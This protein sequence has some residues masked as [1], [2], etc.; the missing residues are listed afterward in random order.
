M[1]V[2]K[3]LFSSEKGLFCLALVVAASVLAIMGKLTVDQWISYTEWIAAVYVGGKAIQGAGAA[4]G[5]GKSA[6][7]EERLNANDDVIDELVEKLEAKP[8]GKIES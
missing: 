7:L 6:A 8:V 3:D 5:N 2:L 1:K 4:I